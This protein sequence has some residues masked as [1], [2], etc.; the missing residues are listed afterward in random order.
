MKNLANAMTFVAVAR[1]TSFAKAANKLGMS[2]S[3]VSKAVA[4][5]EAELNI[6][7]LHRTTRSVS[8]TPEG[9]SY[10]HGMSQIAQNLRDLNNEVMAHNTTPRG[11]LTVSVPPTYG[12]QVLMP[13]LIMHR[14]TSRTKLVGLKNRYIEFG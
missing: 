4:R 8:L 6:K 13:R 2:S 9:E 3:A 1:E 5:L 11:K 10:L 12:R 14:W 7:L